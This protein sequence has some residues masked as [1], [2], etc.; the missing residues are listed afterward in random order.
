L[1]F[2]YWEKIDFGNSVNDKSF[3]N[4]L[5]LIYLKRGKFGKS[6]KN[7]L[8]FIYLKKVEFWKYDKSS[9]MH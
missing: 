9:K 4:L 3:K 5:A 8:A 1:I 7:V 6:S 2:N